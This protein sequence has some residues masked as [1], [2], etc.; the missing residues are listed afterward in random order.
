VERNVAASDADNLCLGF[1]RQK[2]YP[3]FDQNSGYDVAQDRPNPNEAQDSGQMESGQILTFQLR[4]RAGTP[5]H[6]PITPD[7]GGAEP[8]DDLAAFE[9]EDG[10]IDYRHRMLMNVFAVVI[11]S[12]LIT[13]GV[14][15]ADTIAAM[16]K[17]Q[18]CAL[19]G[20]QNCAPIDV[21]VTKK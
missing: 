10:H 18:D 8:V 4:R 21:P 2:R 16:Q 11:V 1:A 7:G 15:I 5:R 13:A 14:W 6:A 12:V 20:R 3:G 19:Q 9:E 17:A